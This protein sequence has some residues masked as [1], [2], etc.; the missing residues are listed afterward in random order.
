MKLNYLNMAK[1]III[2]NNLI[3]L[4]WAILDAIPEFVLLIVYVLLLLSIIGFF[5]FPKIK[6]VDSHIII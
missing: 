5:I 4:I 1:K 3:K 6:L 2:M